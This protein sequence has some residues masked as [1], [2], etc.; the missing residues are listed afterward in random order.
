MLCSSSALTDP[1]RRHSRV[2]ENWQT[3]ILLRYGVARNRRYE[4]GSPTDKPEFRADCS[5]KCRDRPRFSVFSWRNRVAAAVIAASVANSAGNKRKIGPVVCVR[6]T[7]LAEHAVEKDAHV[8]LTTS[9]THGHIGRS[10]R[11][12]QAPAR[13]GSDVLPGALPGFDVDT[14]QTLRQ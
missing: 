11:T 8:C 13:A 14:R 6:R 12:A 9:R 2:L 1:L 5:Q 4:I 10:G 7:H 3:Q